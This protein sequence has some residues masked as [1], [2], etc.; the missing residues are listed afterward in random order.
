MTVEDIP[1][2]PEVESSPAIAPEPEIVTVP[3]EYAARDSST[4]PNPSS[5]SKPQHRLSLAVAIVVAIFVT[6]SILTLG[7]HP[8]AS[9]FLHRDGRAPIGSIAV[10]PLQNLSGDPGE[11]YF[12]DGMTDELITDLARIPNL[13]IVS[14]TSVMAYKGSRSQ[15]LDIASQL[16]IVEG[17]IVRSGNRIRITAQLID[18]RTDRHLWPLPL[19]DPHQMSSPSRTASPSKSPPRPAWSSS[20]PRRASPSTP[21]HTMPISAVAIS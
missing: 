5:P 19:K 1:A 7:S 18:A 11:E 15:L 21:P 2:P 8:L 9:R 16:A 10:L 13:R 17:F 14:R 12:A 6:I 3:D 20:L 4:G